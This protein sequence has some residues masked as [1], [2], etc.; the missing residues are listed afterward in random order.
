MDVL[1][2]ENVESKTPL[3]GN[4]SIHFIISYSHCTEPG[5]GQVRGTEPGLMGPNILHRNIYTVL[6][7]GQESDIVH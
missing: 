2:Q 6:T 7:Q 5:A 1:Q 4:G 3:N